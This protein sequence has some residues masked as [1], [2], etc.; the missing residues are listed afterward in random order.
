MLNHPSPPPT[1]SS[2]ELQFKV[3]N[4]NEIIQIDAN[5][6]HKMTKSDWIN[7]ESYEKERS[8]KPA[9]FV[10]TKVLPV[11]NSWLKNEKWFWKQ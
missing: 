4:K 2:W 10:P 3:I 1:W 8:Y 5:P 11:S 6:L 7:W 9:L